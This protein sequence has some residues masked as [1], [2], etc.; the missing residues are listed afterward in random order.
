[1][2]ADL[3]F[4]RLSSNSVD[5]DKMPLY[6]AFHLGLHCLQK[7]SFRGFPEYKGLKA[8]AKKIIY[9]CLLHKSSAAFFLLTLFAYESMGPRVCQNVN[10]TLQQTTKSDNFCCD[11]RFK[12]KSG[13]TTQRHVFTQYDSS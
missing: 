10:E 2:S 11:W 8:P 9:K 6:A 12:G 5:P 13:S 3:F 4:F 1:M 7:Y